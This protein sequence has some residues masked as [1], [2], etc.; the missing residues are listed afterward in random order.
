MTDH[1]QESGFGKLQQC[2]P[3]G[4]RRERSE[5]SSECIGDMLCYVRL[6]SRHQEAGC[7]GEND[8]AGEGCVSGFLP[9]DLAECEL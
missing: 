5:T 3:G 6:T 7:V 4:E 9:G 8:V 2:R 1:G